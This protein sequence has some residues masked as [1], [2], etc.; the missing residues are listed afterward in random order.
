MFHQQCGLLERQ[1]TRK[2]VQLLSTRIYSNFNNQGDADC[3][4][5]AELVPHFLPLFMFCRLASQQ[6][7]IVSHFPP[8]IPFVRLTWASDDLFSDNDPD[9]Q[10]TARQSSRM[11]AWVGLGLVFHT[12]LHTDIFF[13]RRKSIPTRSLG[14]GPTLLVVG[15]I[16]LVPDDGEC[17]ITPYYMRP[18]S[19]EPNP[20]LGDPV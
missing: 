3:R 1:W 4:S 13:L 2:G 10:V 11:Q 7:S 8:N 5:E 17:S 12:Y 6:K 16:G 15:T 19:G 18:N 9:V 20:W 14:L